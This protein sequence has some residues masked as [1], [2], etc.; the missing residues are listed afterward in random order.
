V[1]AAGSGLA[2]LA[3][4]GSAQSCTLT[5]QLEGGT[6]YPFLNEVHTAAGPLALVLLVVAA[7][8]FFVPTRR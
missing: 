5:G 7:V 4:T 8:L 1:V 6:C 2:W 3:T